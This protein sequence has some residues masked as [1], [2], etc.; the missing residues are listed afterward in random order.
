MFLMHKQ[1]PSSTPQLEA[2]FYF[3]VTELSEYSRIGVN[4]LYRALRN[5]ELRHAVIGQK[6]IIARKDFEAWLKKRTKM[7][8]HDFPAVPFLIPK[9]KRTQEDGPVRAS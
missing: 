4:T 6:K 9:S 3:T 8:L 1:R 7:A 5:R 2:P